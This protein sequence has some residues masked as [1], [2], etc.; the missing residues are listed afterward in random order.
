MA[1]GNN[2]LDATGSMGPVQIYNMRGTKKKVIRTHG[3]ASK[4]KIK[5]SKAFAVTRSLNAE[6]K[7]VTSVTSSLG[8]ALS[9]LKPM[10]D[11]NIT[12]PLNASIKKIQV[13]DTENPKGKRSILLSRYPQF[14]GSFSLNRDTLL[15]SVIRQ[16]LYFQIDP[17]TGTTKI[18]IPLLQPKINF[19][20]DTRY[21]YFR[22]VM[23]CGALSDQIFD[24][25]TSAYISVNKELPDFTPIDSAWFQT[26]I[27][28]ASANYQIEV[29]NNKLPA[30][31]AMLFFSAGI[32]YGMPGP[33][34]SIQPVPY[35][36]TGRIMQCVG[37]SDQILLG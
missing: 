10:A 12:G 13:L 27:M 19:F 1:T 29:N 14:L 23:D 33:D 11:F 21:A 8:M 20:P 16:P 4:Q 17:S 5:T 24:D 26:N 15:E 6:W 7:A 30:P 22:L 32:Q 35:A 31:G 18:T 28:L 36:G 37:I 34:G 3:G 2:I 25:V 9:G